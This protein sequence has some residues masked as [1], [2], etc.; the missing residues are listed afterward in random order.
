[1]R[2]VIAHGHMFKNAGSTLDW[3]LKKNFGE[4]FLDHRDDKNMRLNGAELLRELMQEQ[5][6]LQVLSSHHLY[7]PLPELDG[8][9]FIPIFLLRHPIDRIA[10]VYTFERKQR[11]ITP[12]AK[13]AR[14]M[15]FSSYVAWRMQLDVPRTIRDY[16]TYY[17]GGR[18]K[19]EAKR[20]VS[21][22]TLRSAIQNMVR[23][24]CVGVVDRYDE[25]MVVFENSL[26]EHFPAID[27]AYVKQNVSRKRWGKKT[28]IDSKVDDVLQRLD[29]LSSTVLA[30]N[31]YDLSLYRAANQKLDQAIKKIEDFDIR[32]NDFRQRC[33]AI[34][35]GG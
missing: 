12:G 15:N 14:S 2:I 29:K 13:A 1:M 25:S 30:N 24:S 10:S 11:G 16:Q 5:P 32:L 21:F 19:G 7:Q 34:G 9:V 23:M 3:S 4:T 20:A 22:R 31:S 28:D 17:I 6:Q 26:R 27:L 8:I 33:T 18:P 35:G